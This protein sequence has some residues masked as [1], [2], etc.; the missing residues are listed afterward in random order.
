M[1]A[2][3]LDSSKRESNKIWVDQGS[4]FY[5]SL[6]KKWFK[7]NGIKM[8]STN[9]EGKSVFAERFVITFQKKRFLSIWQLYQKIFTLIPLTIKMKP[10]DV[11][12]ESYAECNVDYNEKDPK[13]KLGDHVKI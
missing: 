7:D 11:K 5:D 4:E 10:I 6:F 1:Y 13:F 3:I 12:S 9:N 2:S 8:Y